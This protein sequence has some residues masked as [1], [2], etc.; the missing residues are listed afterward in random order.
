MSKGIIG[1]DILHK[2]AERVSE[3]ARQKR[4]GTFRQVVCLDENTRILDLGSES[5]TNISKVLRGSR[6]RPENVYIADIKPE[7]IEEGKRKHGFTPVLIDEAKGLPFEDGYFDVVFCSS[8]IEH[9][10]VAKEEVWK[11]RSGSE[12]RRRSLERQQGFA[13]EIAR[14]G[15]QYFVQ[16]PYRYFLIES[17]TWLPLLSFVPRR[18]LIPLLRVTNRIWIKRTQPDWNLLTKP[19]LGRMFPGA[20]VLS[21][22]WFGL[23]KSI[24]AVGHGTA[25]DEGR[26]QESPESQLP[27]DS[28]FRRKGSVDPR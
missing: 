8:V 7:L 27:A 6:V 12:F 22:R 26:K 17:H 25:S 15:K 19:D 21:E 14:L 10:T 18:L 1:M 23:T 11:L 28:S 4:G 9:V 20:K 3:R 5:G 13:T 2:L 16:T 24:M